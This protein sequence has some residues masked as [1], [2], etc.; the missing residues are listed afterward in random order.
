MADFFP[1]DIE[2]FA[3]IAWWA[4]AGVFAAHAFGSFIRGAFGFGSNMPIVIITT[5]GKDGGMRTGRS[6]SLWSRDWSSARAS[7]PGCSR[8]W[9][10]I[11]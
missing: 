11:G 5:F 8:Y 10:R 3:G 7:E 2:P 6:R 4:I 1:G 9:K